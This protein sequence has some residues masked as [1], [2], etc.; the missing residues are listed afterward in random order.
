MHKNVSIAVVV[1]IALIAVG[2][3]CFF[4]LLLHSR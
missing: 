2:Q 4:L 3:F 1:V